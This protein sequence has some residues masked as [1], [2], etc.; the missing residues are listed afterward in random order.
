MKKTLLVISSVACI[1]GA[2]FFANAQNSPDDAKEGQSRGGKMGGMLRAI[3]TNGD[4]VVSKD[5]FVAD[6]NKR[7]AEMDANKDNKITEEELEKFQEAKKAEREKRKKEIEAEQEKRFNEM[8][9]DKD[10]KISKEEMKNHRESMR[11]K[12]KDDKSDAEE[13]R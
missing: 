9:T 7:F 3:D 8:D 1:V 2:V 5:E 6:S 4:K 10:G 12:K 11:D 13:K